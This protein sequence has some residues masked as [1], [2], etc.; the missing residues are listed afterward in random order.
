MIGTLRYKICVLAA[1]YGGLITI[2]S[3][4]DAV[5]YLF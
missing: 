1:S 3:A 2:I 4:L 5:K